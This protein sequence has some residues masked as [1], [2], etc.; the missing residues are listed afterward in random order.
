MFKTKA[1][2]EKVLYLATRNITGKWGKPVA[3]WG[4]ILGQFEAFF[5]EKMEKYLR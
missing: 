2:L 4:K 1:S 5:P 3:N